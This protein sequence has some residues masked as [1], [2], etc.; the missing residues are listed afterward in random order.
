MGNLR[1]VKRNLSK[2]HVWL[3]EETQR[4]KIELAK[5]FVEERCKKDAEFAADVI[6]AVGE[7]LPKEIKEVAEATIAASKEMG[8][9]HCGELCEAHTE[10]NSNHAPVAMEPIV[11]GDLT[12]EMVPVQTDGGGEILVHPTELLDYPRDGK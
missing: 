1:S 12:H 4:Q 9:C 11:G 2:R 6:K 3:A 7:N 10:G 8:V 5:K